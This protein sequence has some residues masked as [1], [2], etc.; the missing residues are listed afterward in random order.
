MPTPATTPPVIIIGAGP[1]GL[2]LACRL[3][4]LGLTPLVLEQATAPRSSSRAVGIHPPALERLLA[5]GAAD[6]LLNRGVRVYRGHGYSH[7]DWVG[8][9]D[10]TGCARPYNHVLTLPQTHTEA[11]LAATAANLGV[12]VRRGVEALALTAA[13]ESATLRLRAA[14]GGE[15]ELRARF[16]IGCDG[17][18]SWVRQQLHIPFDGAP[19]PDHY[20]MG[21]FPDDTSFGHDAYIFMGA[22]GLVESFPLPGGIRRWVMKTATFE[23]TPDLWDFRRRVL[24]RTGFRLD[25]T[26]LSAL[27]PFTAEHYLAARQCAESVLLAGDAAHIISPIGGQG[28][29][30]G[31][32]NAW[33]LATTVHACLQTPAN[34]EQLLATYE[35]G[36][37]RRVK[38]CRQRAEFNMRMGRH[39]AHPRRQS[40]FLRLLLGG[41]PGWV[42]ARI[43]TM[44][45]L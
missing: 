7:G 44:R 35:T 41:P 9:I 21:D 10:F 5:I 34:A 14:A 22:D 16:V 20:V 45:W 2:F 15:E 43:F 26:L 40:T 30:L 23:A 42:L 39:T 36:A 27:S 1:V 31:W 28:L 8:T 18:H 11:V 3:A 12:T 4:Q 13:A 6:E 19:Y 32:L 29:N 17:K 25:A 37:R 38:R 24:Q 33:E